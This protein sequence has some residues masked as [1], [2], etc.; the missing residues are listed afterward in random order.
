MDELPDEYRLFPATSLAKRLGLAPEELLHL[1]M[2]EGLPSLFRARFVVANPE[3]KFKSARTWTRVS[4]PDEDRDLRAE[5]TIEA[6]V[7]FPLDSYQ[8]LIPPGRPFT[9]GAV[10]LP[11]DDRVLE[12]CPAQPPV[13]LADLL[14]DDDLWDAFTDKPDAD[15]QRLS[16][17]TRQ[18][19]NDLKVIRAFVLFA[20]E[21]DPAK[22]GTANKVRTSALARALLDTAHGAEVDVPSRGTVEDRLKEAMAMPKVDQGGRKR[23][24]RRRR[25]A[26]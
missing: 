15:G 21:Q 25:D 6:A 16:S 8:E 23:A 17:E 11:D 5:P 4:D 3:Q 19:N 13:T 1:A 12:L 22:F 9:P 2:K 18:R 7:P 14:V 24:R 20:I 26:N 10:V